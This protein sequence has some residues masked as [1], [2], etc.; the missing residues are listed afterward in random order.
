MADEPFDPDRI[1]PDRL[2]RMFGEPQP[3]AKDQ[4]FR[5]GIC[6]RF[7]EINARLSPMI[8]ALAYDEMKKANGDAM[9]MSA[10]LNSVVSAAAVF[11]A[12]CLTE[13][14]ELDEELLTKSTANLKSC[15]AQR[16]HC[17]DLVQKNA[18]G[19][20]RA[21]LFEN[22]MPGIRTIIQQCSDGLGGV[23][24]GLGVVSTQLN[25]LKKGGD[26]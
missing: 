22:L 12:A 8:W 24:K 16:E 15:L 9:A 19:L 10:V 3:L 18:Q 7:E 11:A 1:D 23:M 13:G 4:L 20:G 6:E 17:I 26:A 14:P 2:K 25:D 21:L 5:E